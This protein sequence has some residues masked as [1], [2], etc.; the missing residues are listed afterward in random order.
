[1]SGNMDSVK[2]KFQDMV[3][4]NGYMWAF[5]NQIQAICKINLDNFIMEIVVYYTGKERFAARKIFL[6]QD[7][8]YMVSENSVNILVFD[9]K[10]EKQGSGFCLEKSFKNSKSETYMAFLYNDCIYFIPHYID[11]DVIC[12]DLSKRIYSTKRLFVPIN[13]V[14]TGKNNFH[15]RY[16]YSYGKDIWFVLDSTAYYGRYDLDSE[17]I[18]LFQLEDTG[19]VLNS[20]CFDGDNVW[21]TELNNS[22]VIYAG[23]H[24]IHVP[25]K[26]L[27]GR[28]CSVDGGI[29]VFPSDE[30]KL[31][32]IK[33][34][35]FEVSIVKLPLIESKRH[36]GVMDFREYGDF[37]FLLL[38]YIGGVFVFNQ[39]TLEIRY[40]KLKCQSYI[41]ECF[42]RKLNV[43]REDEDIGLKQLL[44]FSE[45]LSDRTYD[46]EISVNGMGK[47]IWKSMQNRK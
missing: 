27:Y 25:G 26:H 15:S 43:L 13:R 45:K 3:I 38:V 29:L 35:T 22:N 47:A 9:R 41:K 30:D 2:A 19:A 14:N 10:E 33:K 5:D 16:L 31:V 36:Y 40:I 42:Q 7:K 23:R 8:F 20:C 11:K 44:L 1:M 34:K 18:D 46:R 24:R 17:K 32:F 37:V 4:E 28:V 21:L 6:F 39:R 12:F